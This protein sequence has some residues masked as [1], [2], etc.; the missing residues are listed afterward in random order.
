MN[1]KL[2]IENWCL[3]SKPSSNYSRKKD[4]RQ[5]NFWDW[6]TIV[7]LKLEQPRRLQSSRVATNWYRN[8][9][10]LSLKFCFL[11]DP[12]V[13]TPTFKHILLTIPKPSAFSEWQSMTA[14]RTNQLPGAGELILK[15]PLPR[16]KHNLTNIIRVH[17][18]SK[19]RSR[20]KTKNLSGSMKTGLLRPF[21]LPGRA[22]QRTSLTTSR[23]RPP[24]ANRKQPRKLSILK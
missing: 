16:G 13:G 24:P 10:V 21:W 23:R 15:C 11:N 7:K 22:S 14:K 4:H 8:A 18:T 3:W 6:R 9:E 19:N 17:F 1:F 5:R 20:N 12:T 2:K